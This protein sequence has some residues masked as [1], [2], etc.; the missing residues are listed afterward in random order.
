[1]TNEACI[2]AVH[3]ITIRGA[4]P[5]KLLGEHILEQELCLDDHPCIPINVEKLYSEA[6]ARNEMWAPVQ[7]WSGG[8]PFKNGARDRRVVLKR[9]QGEESSEQGKVM[10]LDSIEYTTLDEVKPSKE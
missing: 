10:T 2:C 6:V 8:I 3:Q 4:P 9:M 1:M 5:S 7:I